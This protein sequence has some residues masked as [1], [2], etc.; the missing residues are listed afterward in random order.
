MFSIVVIRIERAFLQFEVTS[1]PFTP[2][3]RYSTVQSFTKTT[4]LPAECVHCK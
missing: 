2:K 1:F 4:L 3:Y